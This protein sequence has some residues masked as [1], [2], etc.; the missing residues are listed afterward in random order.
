M[1]LLGLLVRPVLLVDMVA[2]Q[3]I[4]HLHLKISLLLTSLVQ[5]HNDLETSLLVQVHHLDMVYLV[6]VLLGQIQD[7]VMVQVDKKA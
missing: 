7:Q 2:K 3:S 4:L 5:P 1:V 6:M